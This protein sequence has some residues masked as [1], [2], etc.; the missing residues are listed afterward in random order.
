MT[1]KAQV[2]LLSILF[3][4]AILLMALDRKGWGWLLFFALLVG[5][6]SHKCDGGKDDE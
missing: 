3:S 6:A 5:S 4:G 1:I 2:I